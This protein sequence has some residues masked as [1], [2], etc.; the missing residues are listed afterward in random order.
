VVAMI[1]CYNIA[2]FGSEFFSLLSS[3]WYASKYC[4]IATAWKLYG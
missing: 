3:I 1:F 4:F 2:L